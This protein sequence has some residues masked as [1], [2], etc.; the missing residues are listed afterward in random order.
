MKQYPS[1]LKYKKNHKLNFSN[2]ILSD[3]K[4]FFPVYGKY[5]L[6]AIESGN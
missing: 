3:Q 4:N 6:K 1:R 2:L 5:F